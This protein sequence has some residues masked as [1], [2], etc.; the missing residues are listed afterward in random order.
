MATVSKRIWTDLK[1]RRKEAWRI[2]Y[3]DARG[4]RRHVQRRTKKDADA[5]ALTVEM[6]KRLGVHVPDADS[7]TIKDAA[8]V[9][10]GRAEADGCD[11]GTLKSYRE[12]ANTHIIPLL[13]TKRLTRL[14]GPE[15]V[16]FKDA[17][18]ATR[19]RAMTSK[20]V[21]HLSMILGESVRRGLV[22]QNVA[23]GISVKRPRQDGK[24]QRL[25]KRAEI[26]PIEHLKR[27]LEAAERL[28]DEDPRLPVLLPMVM[29][30]GLRASEARALTW[31][32][33]NVGNCASLTVTQRADRW[34]DIGPPKSD[35][36]YRT[37]PIG[38]SLARRL[39]AWKLRCPPC[40]LS[41]VFPASRRDRR[42]STD[43]AELGYGPIKQGAF[44]DL[45]LKVQVRA[46][47][48]I[49]TG[50]KDAKG[51]TIWKSRYGWHDLRH[52]AASNWLNDGIDLKRLQTWIGHESIQLTID[53]YGH[54]IADPK[55][56]AALAAGAEAALLA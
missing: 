30:A 15:V 39:K 55:K 6:E 11:R 33:A 37:I 48:A 49:D 21:R 44:S 28:G 52:V 2:S 18:L 23:R 26:P 40:P 5:Y 8:Q 54:L 25:A 35:A 47:L 46:G 1:G 29:L 3:V 10:L 45:F 14:T 4:N 31:A 24:R 36:G 56:D 43:R 41:L 16:A 42:W 32:N 20:A 17:L 7:L 9:W 38:P 22:G 50:R 53:V 12:I 27:L 34:N 51:Q 13:G 19:S